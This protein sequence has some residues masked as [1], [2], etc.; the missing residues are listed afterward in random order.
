MWDPHTHTQ[1]HI[2]RLEQINIR[3][4]R[5]ITNNFTRTPGI[6]TRLKQQI[7]MEPLHLRR[8]AHTLTLMYKIT[9]THIDIDAQTYLHN[10]NSQRTRNTH[11]HKYQ[12][13]HTNTDAYK[14]SYFPRT[15][16]HWNSL[17]KQILD[18]STIDSFEKQIHTHLSPQH[19]N[20]NNYT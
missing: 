2:D 13:Y 14:H 20:T 17:P 4:A 6:T 1:R 11:I 5:F 10:A 12:T 9:N 3:A 16:H 8:Q 15:T 7:N 19:N 18:L